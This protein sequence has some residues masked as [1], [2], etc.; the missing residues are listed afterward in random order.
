MSNI[1]PSV[2]VDTTTDL[3]LDLLADPTKI[4]PQKKTINL[5]NI[6]ESDDEA[7]SHVVD[8]LNKQS[9]NSRKS[10]KSETSKSSISSK[11]SKSSI[12]SNSSN[13]S[14]KSNKNFINNKPILLSQIPVKPVLPAA[15]APSSN[16]FAS[17]FGG[18]VSA[19][20]QTNTQQQQQQP[21]AQGSNQNYSFPTNQ[22]KD[23]YDT[24]TDDQKRL[25]RLQKFAELKYIKDTYKVVLT[26]EFSYNSDYH[27]MCAEIEFHRSNISKKNS[28]E[29]FKSMVFGSVGMVDKLNK[30]FDPFGL[31]DTLDG[32]P[33]HLQ[34]TTKDSEIYEEL[35]DK[36]KSKFKEY[37]VE[38]RFVLLIVGSAAGFIATKKA[39]ES[40]PFFN[41]LDEGMKKEMM[42]N[43]SVN[44]QNNIVPQ[45][46]EQKAKE[47]QAK[48]MQFMMQQKRQE[49]E[50]NQRMQNVLKQNDSQQKIFE[51]IAQNT[52]TA[53][54]KQNFLVS[55]EIDSEESSVQASA[56]N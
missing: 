49:E 16:F 10:S 20:A 1:K 23:N 43:L 33:E 41:N 48:I 14:N 37:S 9:P 22:P 6:S 45:T 53:I 56:S 44:I 50:K 32:F 31:K 17:F 24:L 54:N 47:E 28:V 13:S 30:M 11:S 52:K 34:M 8:N 15:P 2:K 25:K 12:S 51:Q 35:A 36:Y 27:E 46:A 42:R 26:K 18:G 4:K 40:I 7:D 21:P 19:P 39:A 29:F 38:M 55:S 3:H 5:T